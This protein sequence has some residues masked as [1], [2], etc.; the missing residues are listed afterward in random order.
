MHHD[1]QNKEI[2][3]W[4]PHMRNILQCPK[5]II[6]LKLPILPEFPKNVP[7]VLFANKTIRKSKNGRF[8]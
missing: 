2:V 7:T 1:W 8:S 6:S 3:L 5:G 4:M